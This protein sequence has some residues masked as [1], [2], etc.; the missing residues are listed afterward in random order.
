MRKV[1]ASSILGIQ[2]VA[3]S[4][5]ALRAEDG[6]KTQIKHDPDSLANKLIAKCA[7]VKEGDIVR[8]TGGAR[9]VELL[10]SLKVEA[11]KLG[12]DTLV[13]LTSSER[14]MRRLYTDVPAKYDSRMSPLWLKLAETVTVAVTVDIDS[15]ES[16]AAL[17]NIPAERINARTATS[18]KILETAMK[19]NVRQVFLGNG[20]YPT[21]ARA[22]QLG[23]SK[24]DLAK[25]FYDGLDVDLDKLRSSAESVRK[26]LSGGK[27]AHITTPEGTDLSVEIANRPSFVTDGV[28]SDD[29]LKK[30]GA[31][32]LVWLP[33]GEVFLTPVPGTAEGK[34][35]KD[36]MLFRGNEVVGLSLTFKKGKLTEM[37][38]KSGLEQLQAAYDA[39]GAGKDEFSFLDIGLNPAVRLPKT[40]PS[41]VFMEAGTITVGTGYNVWAG[42][43]EQFV[44]RGPFALT[45]RHP[46]HRRQ[47]PGPEWDL[48]G[49]SLTSLK[50]DAACSRPN[51]HPARLHRGSRSELGLDRFWRTAE[52]RPVFLVWYPDSKW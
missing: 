7:R 42:G 41:G 37:T 24:A 10:E 3:L 16:Q 22:K 25:L 44:F 38:A 4:L 31:A 6:P 40:S 8:I 21:D 1:A 26:A 32:C 15:A 39:S 30:G 27:K 43:R 46:D 13:T 49:P 45:R 52:I 51:R 28:L 11:E 14:T 29:R 9:D 34:V 20:L 33:A 12:A 48:V 19:R 23:L 50:T 47:G 2:L 5:A 18:V 17:A 35:V 36:R